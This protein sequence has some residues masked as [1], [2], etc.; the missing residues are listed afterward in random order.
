MKDA[1]GAVQSILVVGGSS[2]IGVAIA[3]RLA[4]PRRATVVLAGR[5]GDALAAAADAVKG[6]GAGEVRTMPFDAGAP[7]SHE[8][9]VQQVAETVGDVDVAVLAF[10]VL[11]DQQ[12]DEQG[13]PGA[14]EV[15]TTNYVGTVSVGLALGRLLRRQG[16]GTLVVLSSVAGERVRR[17]NFIYGSSKAGADGFAQGLGDWLAGSGAR[18]LIVRPGFVTSKMTAGMDPAPLSTTPD[19]VAD[20]VAEALA[21]GREVIWVPPALRAVMSVTRHLPRPLFRRLPL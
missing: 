12:A 5:R 13:G 9:F 17:A 8:A 15:A 6:A 2:D 19:K 14:V 4:P 21:A 3:R 20:A 10:G 7:E 18:V 16:H 11:G 1:L